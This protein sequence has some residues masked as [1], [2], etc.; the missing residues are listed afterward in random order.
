[1]ADNA[2]IPEETLKRSLDTDVKL[3][4]PPQTILPEDSAV[5]KI[6]KPER[7]GSSKQEVSEEPAAKRVKIEQHEAT[8]NGN[9]NSVPDSRD[10]VRGVALVK[11]E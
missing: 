2:P 6:E 1:M 5:T 9:G 8:T 7:N 4:Y 10:K 11:P 3:E